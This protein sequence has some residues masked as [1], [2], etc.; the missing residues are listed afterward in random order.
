MSQYV[1]DT[2]S[3]LWHLSSDPRLSP[4][5]R[6]VFANADA[7]LHQAPVPSVVLVEA[8]YLAEEIKTH[9]GLKR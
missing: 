7:G 4:A 6:Q 1:T 2:H 9:Q 3:L 5:A 8:I